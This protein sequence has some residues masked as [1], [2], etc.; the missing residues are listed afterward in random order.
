MAAGALFTRRFLASCES[1]R[2][3]QAIGQILQRSHS[4]GTGTKVVGKRR[5][6]HGFRTEHKPVERAAHWLKGQK[7][8]RPLRCL[9]RPEVE[10]PNAYFPVEM[11]PRGRAARHNTALLRN[12]TMYANL[13][14]PN[15]QIQTNFRYADKHRI[16]RP[17]Y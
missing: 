6:R 10:N 15:C 1:G 3:K 14:T 16:L 9:G 8:S 2:G 13:C 5:A 4:D 7:S 11:L 12:A 17:R